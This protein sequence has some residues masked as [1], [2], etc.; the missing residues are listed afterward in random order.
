VGGFPPRPVGG[1]PPR[2]VGGFPPRDQF[3]RRPPSRGLR[4]PLSL[5]DRAEKG[6]TRDLHR[7]RHRKASAVC[8]PRGMLAG[9][10]SGI[11]NELARGGTGRRVSVTSQALATFTVPAPCPRSP[12][13]ATLV[14]G[15]L[16]RVKRSSGSRRRPSRSVSIRPALPAPQGPGL[17]RPHVPPK[18]VARVGVRGVGEV[19]RAPR[20]ALLGDPSG[21]EPMERC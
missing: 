4:L 15:T 17:T 13:C 7:A 10:S 20:G 6:L 12:L 14:R 19:G 16:H 8:R 2:P 11:S 5:R 18:A 21:G 3:R 1:F 9:G